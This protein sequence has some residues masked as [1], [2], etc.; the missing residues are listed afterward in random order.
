MEPPPP[1]YCRPSFAVSSVVTHVRVR[2][3]WGER[4]QVLEKMTQGKVSS[5]FSNKPPP[6]AHPLLPPVL[7]RPSVTQCPCP[8]VRARVS[9]SAPVCLVSARAACAYCSQVMEHLPPGEDVYGL[10]TVEEAL[11]SAFKSADEYVVTQT[12]YGN[13]GSCAVSVTVHCDREGKVSIIS[14]N[15]GDSRCARSLWW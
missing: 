13:E 9:V 3:R 7:C 6:P 5:V 12:P 11:R 15:L 4:P 8:C 10:S 2:V 14:C 1:P